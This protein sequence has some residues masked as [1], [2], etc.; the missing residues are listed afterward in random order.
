ML[1]S[2]EWQKC[3]EIFRQRSLMFAEYFP[4]E[5]IEFATL[6]CESTTL[7]SQS[8]TLFCESATLFFMD[9]CRKKIKSFPTRAPFTLQYLRLIL[10]YSV[11]KTTAGPL[12]GYYGQNKF[13]PG[14]RLWLP[15]SEWRD[16]GGTFLL[17]I[18]FVCGTISFEN[19]GFLN[20]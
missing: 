11:P 1:L 16:A 9:T 6:F 4:Y 19:P 12:N 2:L 10:I 17:T 8:T 5:V 7:L 13:V 20:G 15:M 14:E 3:W 18:V